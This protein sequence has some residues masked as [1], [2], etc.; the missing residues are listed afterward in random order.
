MQAQR[1]LFTLSQQYKQKIIKALTNKKTPYYDL[2]SHN[3][4]HHFLHKTNRNRLI[5]LS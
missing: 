4:E 1:W 5:M 3:A 2:I